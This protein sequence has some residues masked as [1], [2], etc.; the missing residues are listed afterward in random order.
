M[1]VHL[2]ISQIR[3]RI[4]QAAGTNTDPDRSSTS[5]LLGRIFHESIASFIGNHAESGWKLVMENADPSGS[6]WPDLLEADLYERMIGPRIASE[7]VYLHA[8][9]P[10]VMEFW[11]ACRAMCRWLSEILFEAG[12]S[13]TGKNFRSI[14]LLIHPEETIAVELVRPGWKD[15]VILTG[16]PDLFLKIAQKPFWCVVEWKLGKSCPEADLTQAC[17][18]HLML[19]E[20]LKTSCGVLALIRFTPEKQELLFS[21]SEIQPVRAPLM[22]MIGTIAGVSEDHTKI[23]S[24]VMEASSYGPAGQ[25][26]DLQHN[27]LISIFREYGIDI[28]ADGI[29]IAG[30]AFIRFPIRLGKGVKITTTRNT[31]REIQHRMNLMSPPLIHLSQGRVVVDIQRKD[32]LP[33][34]F[35]EILGQ[36]RKPGTSSGNSSVILGV[37]L[38]NRLVTADLNE[39]ENAHILVAGTTGS[40]KSEWIRAALAG[41]MLTNS[42]Q[43]LRLVVIDPKRCTFTDIT[44]SD[45][46]LTPHS[47]IYPDEQS[48]SQALKDLADEMD[49]RYKRLQSS[50]VDSLEQYMERSDKIMPR[51]VCVCDEYADLI[52]R[53]REERKSVEAEINR[54][55][56]KA[57]SVGIHLIIA[58]Q[59][60]SRQT[61]RGAL[62]ANLP[63]RIALKMNRDIESKMILGQ[64]G[65]E[66]LL[67]DGDMLFKNIGEPERLQAPL[68]SPEDRKRI[69]GGG[70]YRKTGP[71]KF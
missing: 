17:L 9:T 22:E 43:T 60:P 7:Q 65:A 40:G 16:V 49:S 6:D 57:R 2:P 71:G 18:Y 52:Q 58:T 51:I 53:D 64:K 47:L 20:S 41:L 59:H 10:A 13:S 3:R 56:Q 12:I 32:R 29:P 8:N 27:Q 54:L 66:N 4:F 11:C 34:L 36:Y 68:L 30:P 14:D 31:A 44:G 42:P 26:F 19:T 24:V 39:P 62:D 33:V 15:S 46:L 61:I 48:V 69:F 23:N 70:F 45:F 63:A 35:G 1:P 25:E 5:S 67:G 21:S 50:G 55:G 38:T 37:N 28:L